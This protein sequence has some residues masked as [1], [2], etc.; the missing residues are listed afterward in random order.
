V[1]SSE[2]IRRIFW[3]HRWL[4]VICMILPAAATALYLEREPVTFTATAQVQGQST[5]PDAA[6]QVQAIQG[7]VAAVATDPAIVQEAMA[8]AKVGGDAAQVAK[9]QVTVTPL[10]SSAV[11][12]VTVTEPS[13]AAAVRLDRALATAV[14]DHIDEL[15]TTNNPALSDLNASIRKLSAKRDALIA[16]LNA[17]E[18]G[19]QNG[20]S[21]KVQ[22]LL[23]Q[24]SA[25]EQQLS[26]DTQSAQQ[27]VASTSSGA[28]VLAMPASAT[29]ASRHAAEYGALA[30]LLGLVVGLLT[31]TIRETV[32]PTVAQ[33]GAGARELG[34]VLLGNAE[35]R[36]DVPASLDDDLAA[37]L[38]LAAQRLGTHT[39]VLA[40]PVAGDRLRAL[41]SKLS[42]ELPSGRGLRASPS[43][44][45]AE[46]RT[47]GGGPGTPVPLLTAAD[48]RAGHFQANGGQQGS[49]L[50]P[51]P[52]GEA[53]RPAIQAE[54]GGLSAR[55]GDGRPRR[56]VAMGGP[57]LDG[58][59]GD[60][61]LAAV[62]PPFAPHA[63]LDQIADL[64]ATTG[65]PLLGVIGLRSHRSGRPPGPGAGE[66][67][68]GS[69]D[70]RPVPDDTITMGAVT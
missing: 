41:A 11:M 58:D 37:R 63:A 21:V 44:R 50:P 56:V 36:G 38:D 31:A 17:A 34:T 29:G 1:E 19:G 25:A 6:T 66:E 35:L 69:D 5:T 23:T 46:H 49:G 22:S 15:G 45:E 62:L 4:L 68:G 32:R 55:S 64:R 51:A 16:E 30:A 2:A 43:R 47:R 20:S 18:S 27:L 24:L 7:R 59:P 48:G 40:G 12:S 53:G 26:S 39:I 61:G 70:I 28:A 14:V 42:R 60:A 13:R 10:G 67:A 9:H 52:G 33:P 3:R 54:A 8:A 65:W 57:A